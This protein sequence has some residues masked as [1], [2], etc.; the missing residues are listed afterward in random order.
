MRRLDAG[1]KKEKER[2]AYTKTYLTLDS[3][4]ET[5]QEEQDAQALE[6]RV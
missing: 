3:K 6:E 1:D 5:P 2:Q 4:Q